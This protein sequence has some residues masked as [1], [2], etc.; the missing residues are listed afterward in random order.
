MNVSR[1]SEPLALPLPLLWLGDDL[2]TPGQTWQAQW[3]G[4]HGALVVMQDLTRTP[5]RGDWLAQL[6]SAVRSH[7]R[8][9]LM[10]QGLGCA[11]VAAWATYSPTCARVSGALLLGPFCPDATEPSGRYRSWRVVAP[12][13]LPFPAWTLPDVSARSTRQAQKSLAQAW[14]THWLPGDD[15][16]IQRQCLNDWLMS[17][18]LPSFY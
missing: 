10:A 14:G 16:G 2:D 15:P 18:H 12:A 9:R 8:C 17:E 6:E 4:E 13:P 1:L 7:S 11:L 3:A 5:L